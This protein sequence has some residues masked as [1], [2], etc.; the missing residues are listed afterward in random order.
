[1]IF[2]VK[3]TLYTTSEMASTELLVYVFIR[4]LQRK[5][6]I[7]IPSDIFIVFIM[8]YPNYIEFGGS[9]INLTSKEKETKMFDLKDP[10]VI[11]TSKL[12]YDYK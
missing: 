8:F 5:L 6:D 10:S 12:L 1:M 4:E 2:A 9:T 11:L 3:N 7:H